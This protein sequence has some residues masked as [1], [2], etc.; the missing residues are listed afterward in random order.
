[1]AA[2]QGNAQ[3]TANG[4]QF[5]GWGA[6]NHFSEFAPDGSLVLDAAFPPAS[7]ATAPTGCPGRPPRSGR[8]GERRDLLGDRVPPDGI[9]V[10]TG[11]VTFSV[12]RHDAVLGAADAPARLLLRRAGRPRSPRLLRRRRLPAVGVGLHGRDRR[13]QRAG[14][15]LADARRATSFGGVHARRGQRLHGDDDR[16]RDSTA[17]DAALTVADPSADHPGHLVNGAFCA[18]VAADRRRR[19]AARGGEDVGRAG[20]PRRRR[21]SR[22]ASTSA[23]PTRC[24][25]APTPRRS[26]SPC[27]PPT[28]RRGSPSRA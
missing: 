8:V 27:R 16:G 19:A 10:P 24:A 17:G 26:R 9:L 28:P 13:R 18:A 6:Q 15:A 5:V 12:A 25:P 4:D 7:T 3:T 1:M 11:T 2:S 21:R 14:H 20:L 22:S 23:P